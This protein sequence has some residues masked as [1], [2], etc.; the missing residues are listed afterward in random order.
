MNELLLKTYNEHIDELKAQNAELLEALEDV[1][2]MFP[3]MC[4]DADMCNDPH[5]LG[6][7]NKA[8]D[9]IAKGADDETKE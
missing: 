5:T 4:A 8:R 1:M 3:D 6:I 2:V 7:I 9:A